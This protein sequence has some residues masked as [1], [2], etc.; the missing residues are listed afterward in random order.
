MELNNIK[1]ISRQENV[2]DFYNSASV[3]LNLSDKRLFIETF[4]LTVLEAMSCGLPVIVPT[5]GGIAELVEDG[6]NGFKTDVDDFDAI[7]EQIKVLLSDKEL[8]TRLSTN[9]LNFSKNYRAEAMLDK[10]ML[11]LEEYL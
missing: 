8:Y 7:V 3:V 5:V 11:T 1:I 6:Y 10:I 9:S 4:G 2:A